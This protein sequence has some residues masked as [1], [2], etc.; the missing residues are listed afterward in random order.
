MPFEQFVQERILTPLGMKDTDFALDAAHAARL[1]ALHEEKASIEAKLQAMHAA[2]EEKDQSLMTMQEQKA[3][4]ESLR[5]ELE[6][7]LE[8]H[9]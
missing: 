3:A 9:T 1:V 6:A 5:A 2:H 7:E 4:M 8:S